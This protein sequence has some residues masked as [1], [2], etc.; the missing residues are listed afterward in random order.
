MHGRGVAEVLVA[1]IDGGFLIRCVLSRDWAWL[2]LGWVRLAAAFW[3]WQVIC[4]IPGIGIGGGGSLVQALAVARYLVLAAA[5]QTAVLAESEA[6]RW[7][8]WVL[9]VC[10]VYIAGQALLQ[11]AV[12]RN[13]Q[14]FARSGDGALTGPFLHARAGL[15]LSRLIFPTLLPPIAGFLARN[16]RVLAVGTAVFG[17]GTVVLIGQRMPLLLTVLGLVVT[18]LMLPRLRW[19]VMGSL[20]AGGVLLGASAVVAPPTFYRL[21]TKFS[22]QMAGFAE[23]DYGI[24]GGRAAVMALEHPWMGLGFDGFRR[25]CSDPAYFRPF[26]GHLAD[27]GGIAACNIHPHNHYLEIVDNAGFPGLALFSALVVTWLWQLGRGARDPL[28]VGLFVA[29]LLQEWPIASATGFTAMESA[30]FFF[31]LLGYGL[32]LSTAAMSPS[33]AT[34]RM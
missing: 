22:A 8:Q 30:G 1:L 14:G 25:G 15:P 19:L 11:F 28:R 32:A 29:A 31:L 9:T 4:S 23:S 2:R 33:G 26:A 18:G 10:T 3:A 13:L 17:V 24:I 27:G 6:R 20:V 5:L 34:P 21:V 16:Q 7:L 12:G